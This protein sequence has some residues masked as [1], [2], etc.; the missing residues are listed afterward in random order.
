MNEKYQW[1]PWITVLV[2][3]LT[4]FLCYKALETK[5]CIEV[6][7]FDGYLKAGECVAF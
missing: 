7:L 1:R 5:S 6:N 2:I 4:A 3:C